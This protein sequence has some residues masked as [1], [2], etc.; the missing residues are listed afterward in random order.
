LHAL[1]V[2]NQRLQRTRQPDAIVLSNY[3]TLVTV[4][5]G[6]AWFR[7]REEDERKMA[8]VASKLQR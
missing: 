4:L 8:K 2:F 7:T 5:T 6:R 3:E 1:H